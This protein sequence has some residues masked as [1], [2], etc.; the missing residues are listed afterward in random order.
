MSPKRDIAW[1]CH[2]THVTMWSQNLQADL[3]P[4]SAGHRLVTGWSPAGHR[5]VTGWSP[6]GHRL[7]TG[8]SPW[9]WLQVLQAQIL[10]DCV[11][12]LVSASATW[13]WLWWKRVIESFFSARK[14][15]VGLTENV[16]YI[17]NYSHLIGIMIINHWVQWGTLFSD[18]PR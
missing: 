2:V 11:L 17:P 8:W 12:G 9:P 14:K 6:A 4:F 5:L 18:K 10:S 7:V 13:R 3:A 16:G 15:Q 1:H